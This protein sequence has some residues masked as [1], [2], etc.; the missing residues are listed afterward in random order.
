MS[1]V[2]PT[3]PI[4]PTPASLIEAAAAPPP[5]TYPLAD[6][7]RDSYQDLY[8]ALESTLDN[9]STDSILYQPLYDARRDVNSVLDKDSEALI[10]QNTAIFDNLKTQVEATNQS[11]STLKSQIAA[12]ASHVAIAGD[13]VAAI[14]KLF[15]LVPLP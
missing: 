4:P 12:I 5:L 9:I 1:N 7:V 2:P 14:D 10:H 15:T 11:L 8:D 6:P 13:V 3:P